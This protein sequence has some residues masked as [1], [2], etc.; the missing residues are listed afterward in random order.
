MDDIYK[1]FGFSGK[2]WHS[3]PSQLTKELV[4]LGRSLLD[5]SFKLDDF[6]WFFGKINENKLSKSAEAYVKSI[7]KFK[8]IVVQNIIEERNNY[9][10]II[11]YIK[12]LNPICFS[13]KLIFVSVVNS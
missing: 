1:Y 5:L 2:E 6:R 3:L 10:T 13:S 4:L 9:S 8:D 7:D 12:D 11:E